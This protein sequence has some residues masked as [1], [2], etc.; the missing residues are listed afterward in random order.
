MKLYGV[1][2]L[3]FPGTTRVVHDFVDGPFDTTNAILIQEALRLGCTTESK[4]V[5]K[6]KIKPEI[7][8][9]SLPEIKNEPKIVPKTKLT[10]PTEPKQ[11]AT[12]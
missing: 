9:E 6:V 1:G 7:K 10:I 11:E 12:K 2:V 5:S 8:V 3:M 4:V